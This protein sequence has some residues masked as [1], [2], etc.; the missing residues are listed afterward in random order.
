MVDQRLDG[1]G[2]AVVAKLGAGQHLGP[3]LGG[4][5]QP[6]FQRV[7]AD[8]LRQ[9][10]ERA[11]DRESADRRTGRAIGRDLRAVAHHV[12]TGRAHV[13]EVV[14]RKRAQARADER[15]AR[16]GAGLQ[17]EDPIG[18][19]DRA[20]ALAADLH[21]HGRAGRRTGGSEHVFPAYHDLHG[22]AGFAR[23]RDRHRF[24]VDY[25]LAAESAADFRG[26]DAQVAE[27]HIEQLRGV[28]ADDEMPLA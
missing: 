21:R 5:L 11:L 6:K 26:I 24:D 7:H 16:K 25:G 3:R 14:G 19:D 15:R 28:G 18:G 22:M 23:Q 2:I 20:V 12:V 10:V 1:L 27:I 4:V 9:H 17:L 8:L 13:R